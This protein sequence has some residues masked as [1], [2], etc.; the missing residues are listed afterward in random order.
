MSK[1]NG[2]TR[3]CGMILLWAAMAVALPAQTFTT[4]HSFDWYFGANASAS[5]VQGTDGN[6]YG[7]TTQGGAD[8]GFG[9][10]FTL[11]TMKFLAVLI[12]FPSLLLVFPPCQNN[13]GNINQCE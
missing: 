2:G 7:T 1:I 5:L 13:D 3:A 12:P 8:G 10:V 6:F 9:T 4:L 11:D